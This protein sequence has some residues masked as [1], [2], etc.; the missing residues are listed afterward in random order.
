MVGTAAAAGVAARAT[1]IGARPK[2]G[3]VP[4]GA[5]ICGGGSEFI[6]GGGSD[7]SGVDAMTA[8]GPAAVRNKA[9]GCCGDA[10]HEERRAAAS[11]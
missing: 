6:M 4:T 2:S 3:V 1:G 8:T 10:G 5:R 11:E 7:D 9:R